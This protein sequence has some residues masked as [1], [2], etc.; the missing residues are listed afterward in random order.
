MRRLCAVLLAVGFALG[1]GPAYA[2]H[3]GY[4]GRDDCRDGGGCNNERHEN[5]EG[6]GCKY[7]CPTFD[8]SPVQDSFNPT[9]CVMPGSCADNGDKKK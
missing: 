7:V 2:D 9:I 3:G 8:K 5:Y 4:E 1:A 6:A